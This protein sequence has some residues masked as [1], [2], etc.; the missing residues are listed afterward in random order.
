MNV[1]Y[2]L[3]IALLEQLISIPSFS[4][5]EQK[6]A[7]VIDQFLIK[8]NVHTIKKYNNVW[9]YN[10]HFD[11]AKPIILLNSHHDTVRPNPQYTCDPFLP[12]TEGGKLYGL[13]SNDAGG[14][15]V[16]LIATFL[17]F[18][19]RQDLSYNLCLAATA[20]E[21]TSG[22]HG[23]KSILNDLMPISCA[24]VGEPTNMQIAIAEKGSMVL[25]CIS[26]GRAGHAARAEGD[27]AIYKAIKDINW[28]SSYQF[29]IE[30][31]QPVPVK[32]TVTQIKAGIQHNIVPGECSFTVDIRFD[33]SYTQKE[34]LNTIANHTFC[35]TTVRPNV[36]TP[37]AID[38]LHPLVQAGLTV[39][40]KTYLS[41]T[42]S[43]QGWLDMPS[44]KM[45]PGESAR[46]HTANEYIY[47]EEISEGIRKYIDLLEAITLS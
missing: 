22:E 12:F 27:N 7:D 16:S 28:F 11:P 6:T 33:H 36:M 39:G 13:G 4:G 31:G 24:I 14:P 43:D 40:C 38:M 26:T 44:I 45:G 20:E 3:S 41:P 2:K 37:S 18:F 25:D 35:E 21:E 42:S 23:I 46:S 47:L 1:I 9:A 29:P 5:E 10:K 15:L 8:N 34:I 17:H 19:D 30:E 32:M